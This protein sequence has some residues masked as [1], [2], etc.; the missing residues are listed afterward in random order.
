MY[1]KISTLSIVEKML[2][3]NILRLNI[4]NSIDFFQRFYYNQTM[5]NKIILPQERFMGKS[6]KIFTQINSELTHK[7]HSHDFYEVI[8]ITQGSLKHSFKNLSVQDLSFGDCVFIPPGAEHSFYS[9][10]HYVK[11]D[12]LIDKIFFQQ[13]CELIPNLLRTIQNGFSTHVLH[14]NT[15]ELTQLETLFKSFTHETNVST[16]MSLG[17]T[18]LFTLFSKFLK[19]SLEQNTSSLLNKIIEKLNHPKYDID[20]ITAIAADLNYTPQYL[21]HYFK[22]HMGI[23]MT[24]YANKKKLAQIEFYLTNT[25]LSLREIADSVGIESLSY[26]NKIFT[27]QY[28]ITPKKYRDKNF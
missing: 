21:C 6:A 19:T 11:R 24:E 12:I 8:Y 10:K 2:Y 4:K 14:F 15:E 28:G 18:A 22:K 3:F 25:S 7:S 17:L 23:T 5:E 1:S 13:A 9:N 16:R 27:K 20:G 26:M